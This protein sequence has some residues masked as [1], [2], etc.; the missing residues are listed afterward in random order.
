[1]SVLIGFIVGYTV[2]FLIGLLIFSK[3]IRPFLDKEE[4][5]GS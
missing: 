2:F 5:G 3:L 1:M 4:K